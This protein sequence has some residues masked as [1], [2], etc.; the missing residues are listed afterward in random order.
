M[1]KRLRTRFTK[2]FTL[3][4]I[5]IVVAIIAILSSIVLIGIGPTQQLGRDARRASDLHAIQVALSLYFTKNGA[6]PATG[7]LYS[8]MTAAI[9]GGNAMPTDPSTHA[10]Y[11][12]SSVAPFSTYLLW[13]NL[14][15][16]N[17]SLWQGYTAPA[18]CASV[19]GY[20][21]S[22]TYCLTL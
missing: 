6:Y 5:L 1:Q 14:E 10:Q 11:G 18:G 20:V 8:S 3:I 15:N 19:A 22:S 16:S 2:G 21:A 4:E 9:I 17:G 7:N 13:A 12:Y